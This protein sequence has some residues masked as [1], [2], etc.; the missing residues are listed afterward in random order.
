M[1]VSVM[2]FGQLN[3]FHVSHIFCCTSFLTFF[4]P[5]RDPY[6]KAQVQSAPISK[7]YVTWMSRM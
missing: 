5:D 2:S 1:S 6:L 7:L 4:F 3:S